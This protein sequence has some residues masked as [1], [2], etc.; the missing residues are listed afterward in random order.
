MKRKGLIIFVIVFLV[1]LNLGTLTFMWI[2]RPGG[3][4]PSNHR[5]VSAYLKKELLLTEPQQEEYTQ[6]RA[7]HQQEMQNLQNQD[8]ALHKKFFD[9]LQ[10]SPPDSFAA[11]SVADSIATLR[12]KMEILTFNHFIDF[13]KILKQEQQRKFDTIFTE[14]LRMVLPP[15]PSPPPPP[16]QVPPPPGPG[17]PPPPPPPGK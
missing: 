2:N 9:L 4:S 11:E 13:R 17:Q 16:G 10:V 15:P 8:R 6:L 12:K 7:Q 14:V 1:V 3:Q 5:D